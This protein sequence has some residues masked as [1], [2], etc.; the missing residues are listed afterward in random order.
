CYRPCCG[1]SSRF[2]SWFPLL[3]TEELGTSPIPR[4]PVS[5]AAK[6]QY[7]SGRRRSQGFSFVTTRSYKAALADNR[8]WGAGDVLRARAI[9]EQRKSANLRWLLRS[10]FEWMNEYIG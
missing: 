3:E 8:M 9:Y 4:N 5:T 7:G 10:R 2:R 1:G 6:S